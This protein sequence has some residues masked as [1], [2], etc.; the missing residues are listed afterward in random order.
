MTPERSRST[1]ST[2]SGVPVAVQPPGPSVPLSETKAALFKALG[3]PARIRCLEVLAEGERSVGELQPLVGIELSHLSQQLGVL[4]HA[5][6]VSSRKEG[7]SVVY[8][9]KDP[10]LIEL[11]AVARRFLLGS[12]DETRRLIAELEASDS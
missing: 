11:L 4:R 6:L 9:I 2:R 3:H 7:S 8:A 10:L 12:L 1:A 5:G